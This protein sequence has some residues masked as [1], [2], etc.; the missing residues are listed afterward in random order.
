[1][2]FLALI[3]VKSQDK[4]CDIK[5]RNFRDNGQDRCINLE[6]YIKQQVRYRLELKGRKYA[7]LW[8]V[9]SDSYRCDHSFN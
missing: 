7:Q 2:F 6:Q 1:M 9:F 3:T 5:A 4:I 8:L